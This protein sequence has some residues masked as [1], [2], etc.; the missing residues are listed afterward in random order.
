ML[1]LSL[2]IVP[3]QVSK[4]VQT[5]PQR[6]GKFGG[7]FSKQSD[8]TPR[9]VEEQ[10]LKQRSFAINPGTMPS[11]HAWVVFE[12]FVGNPLNFTLGQH[13]CLLDPNCGVGVARVRVERI[14][15]STANKK[16][17]IAGLNS[18]CLE[19]FILAWRKK[20]W[21]SAKSVEIN[22][23]KELVTSLSF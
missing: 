4:A 22:H 9:A 15:K 2:T 3:T 16:F 20:P 17:I 11:G 6:I 23:W 14:V 21:Q 10:G 13:P 19:R 18:W 5:T 7:H 1:I 8:P 12:A